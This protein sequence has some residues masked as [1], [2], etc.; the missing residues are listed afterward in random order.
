MA[1]EA[2][3]LLGFD[4]VLVL[5]GLS[6]V[7]CC[8]CC[9]CLFG[10]CVVV[11]V[12]RCSVRSPAGCSLTG[13]TLAFKDAAQKHG[14]YGV[15]LLRPLLIPAPA[16]PPSRPRTAQLHP[17]DLGVRFCIDPD[18]GSAIFNSKKCKSCDPCYIGELYV[19]GRSRKLSV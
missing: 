13:A 1:A 17:C 7:C 15:Y 5:P 16:R 19:R 6:P 11:V 14:R 4:C 3:A 12:V 18:S 9:C 2:G 10:G 8:C